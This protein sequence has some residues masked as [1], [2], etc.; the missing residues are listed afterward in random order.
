MKNLSGKGN[1]LPDEETT[2]KTKMVVTRKRKV[3]IKLTSEIKKLET[4][5]LSLDK[6]YKQ[7]ADKNLLDAMISLDTAIIALQ[8]VN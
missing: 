2:T 3:T 5:N 7:A 1:W 4:I 8:N 6:K